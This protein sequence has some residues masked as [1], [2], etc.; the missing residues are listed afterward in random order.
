MSGLTDLSS[1]FWRLRELLELLLFKLEE[2]QLLLASGRTRWV[3]HATREVEVVLANIRKAEVVRAAHTHAVARELGLPEDVS[4][5]KLVEQAPPPW[6]DL[7]R[8]HRRAFLTLTAEITALANANRDLL[9][10]GQRAA[11]ETLQLVAGSIETY[12]SR[13]ETFSADRRARLIDE[14]I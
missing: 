5:A 6:N 3:A 9:T 2:E 13:G 7:L 4:L 1:V 8:E 10:R 12:G 11:R 14:A